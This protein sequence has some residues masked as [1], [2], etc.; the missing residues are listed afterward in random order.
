MQTTIRLIKLLGLLIIAAAGY[1]LLWPTSVD[2][3]EWQPATN[4]GFAGDFERN[5]HLADIQTL[6]PAL[7][8]GPEDVTR[9]DVGYFYTGLQ[10][11]R[12]IRFS[13]DG[14]EI[15]EFAN[16]GGRPLGM[17]VSTA[18]NL[19][20]ADAFRGLLSVDLL[21]R[22]TVLTSEADGKPLVFT[23][24]LDISSDGIVWFSD[25]SQRFDQHNYTLDFLEGRP[26]G[27]LLSYSFDTGET[28][29]HLDN[30]HFANGV[31]LSPNEDYVLVNETYAARI[32]RYWISGPKRGSR[33]TFIDSLPGYPD[34]ISYNGNGIFWVAMP[35]PRTTQLDDLAGKPFIR[36]VV[37]RLPAFLRSRLAVQFTWV[38]GID[39][40]GNVIYNLQADDIPYSTITSVNEFDDV[41]YFGS[42][43]MDTVGYIPI[44]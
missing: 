32:T 34:N 15:N 24:D 25:A 19:I 41:L 33:D 3:V 36:K 43:G 31:A 23:D 20:V 11:G 44:P 28:T 1:L 14:R 30:L 6:N 9:D 4:P 10:D 37:S 13:P 5:Q 38:L 12:I 27:R 22:V 21:G 2:P 7:G 39:L 17:Q 42:I 8:F 18:G 35:A 16:T 40:Q 26:T 29:V